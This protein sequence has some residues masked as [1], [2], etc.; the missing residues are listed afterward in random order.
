MP[1]AT[2]HR[3]YKR[4]EVEEVRRRPWSRRLHKCRHPPRRSTASIRS[5][6]EDANPGGRDQP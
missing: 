1:V 6:Q 2:L 3:I 4:L 5:H